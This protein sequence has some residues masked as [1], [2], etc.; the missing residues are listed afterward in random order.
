MVNR[1]PA[2]SLR[3][4]S[5]SLAA[6]AQ[7]CGSPSFVPLGRSQYSSYHPTDRPRYLVN[8]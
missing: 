8:P 2:D 6:L 5:H 1:G 3:C 4:L 7:A